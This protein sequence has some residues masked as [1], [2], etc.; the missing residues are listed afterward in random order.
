MA[1]RL[2][3]MANAEVFLVQLQ[4]LAAAERFADLIHPPPEAA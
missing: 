3:R 2:E 4:V 1:M